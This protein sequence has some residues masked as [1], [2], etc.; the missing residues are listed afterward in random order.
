[1]TT[2]PTKPYSIDAR[3]LN[4]KFQVYAGGLSLKQDLHQRGESEHMSLVL[5]RGEYQRSAFFVRS[6]ERIR[7]LLVSLQFSPQLSGKQP[8]AQNVFAEQEVCAALESGRISEVLPHL[9]KRAVESGGILR[10]GAFELRADEAAGEV[11]GL[12][13]A[14]TA[15]LPAPVLIRAGAF[16]FP[17][18][19]G[20][21]GGI[22]AEWFSQ[23]QV[24]EWD[25]G[26]TLYLF[27][28][29]S[30]EQILSG[31]HEYLKDHDGGPL[32][33]PDD[34]ILFRLEFAH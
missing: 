21:P 2:E 1:L 10:A 20:I 4:I 16:S 34:M 8:T 24:M 33:L 12:V 9:H 29:T 6:E 26:D 27:T 22:V 15:G 31:F 32:D 7:V 18:R 19:S 17:L 5:N 3:I 28:D 11:P 14:V 25:A 30:S 13:H 23:T